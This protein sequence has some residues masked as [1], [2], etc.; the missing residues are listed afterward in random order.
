MIYAELGP[1]S[2]LSVSMGSAS[3]CGASFSDPAWPFSVPCGDSPPE[4]DA[5]VGSGVD[6]LAAGFGFIIIGLQNLST[7]IVF[8]SNHK[9]K[10]LHPPTIYAFILSRYLSRESAFFLTSAD[11]RTGGMCFASVS[12][13][14]CF[15]LI[16]ASASTHSLRTWRV[17]TQTKS[18]VHSTASK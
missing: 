16:Q 11:K 13:C 4:G 12:W 9:S 8:V 7:H 10:I 5:G 15:S 17:E 6:G 14:C 1:F 2:G 18:S 3:G